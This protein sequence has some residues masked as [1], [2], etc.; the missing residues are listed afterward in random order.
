MKYERFYASLLLLA[1]IDVFVLIDR[2]AARASNATLETQRL[3]A[4]GCHASN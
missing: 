3:L 4:G 1:V 2:D